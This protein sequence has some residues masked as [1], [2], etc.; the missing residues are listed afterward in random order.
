MTAARIEELARV[1]TQL[2]KRNA[3]WNLVSVS[4]LQGV[5]GDRPAWRALAILW[6]YEPED[7]LQLV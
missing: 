2:S 1:R 6:T 3:L 4:N 5:V 7:C